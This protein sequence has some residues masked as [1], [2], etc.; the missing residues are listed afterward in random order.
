MPRPDSLT[1]ERHEAIIKMVADGAFID[2]AC[3]LAGVDDSTF[4]RWLKRADDPKAPAKFRVFREDLTR[5]RAEAEQKA[6]NLVLGHAERDWR[7]ATWYLSVTKP[8]R[9]AAKA[10][11]EHVGDGGGPITL[12]GL[13]ALMGL[14]DDDGEDGRDASAGVEAVGL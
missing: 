4:Y 14:A 6:I 5:A 11:I 3:A 12:A 7:A 9:F 1:P 8:E 13:E 2:T 10:R